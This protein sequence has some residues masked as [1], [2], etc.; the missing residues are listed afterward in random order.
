MELFQ[1]VVVQLEKLINSWYQNSRSFPHPVLPYL[2]FQFFLNNVLESY[3]TA[4]RALSSQAVSAI[5]N[6]E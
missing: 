6:W 2:V 1:S 5:S 3:D 4:G